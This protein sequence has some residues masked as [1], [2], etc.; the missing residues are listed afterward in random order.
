[1][2]FVE[3]PRQR[4][5]L[6]NGVASSRSSGLLSQASIVIP[7][8]RAD[9]SWRSLIGDLIQIGTAAELLLVGAASAPSRDGDAS[10]ARLAAPTARWVSAAAGRA[11]QMNLGAKRSTQPF[12]WFLH[13]DSR[14]DAD[15]LLALGGALE[16]HPHAL[17]YFDLAFQG[18]GPRLVRLNAWGA[19][20]RS[21]YLGL[22]FGD[23]GLCMSRDTFERLGGFD[24]T[25]AYGEDHLLVWAAHRHRVP[26]HRVEGVIT[27]SAR[28]YRSNGWLSTTLVHGWRTW[29]QAIPQFGRLLW[30]RCG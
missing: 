9:E 6:S 5:T 17:H 15:A 7:V 20:F 28:K 16:T 10:A 2:D 4:E 3:V 18:D 26:L 12:L 25:A 23:Q 1:M 21:R 22:P 14:V 19:R 29:R 30:K 11:R 13:A 27:T 24:E 8:A